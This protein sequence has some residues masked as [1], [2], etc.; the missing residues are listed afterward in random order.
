MKRPYLT[1]AAISLLILGSGLSGHSRTAA[2]DREN[3]L[4]CHKYPSLA[5]IDEEGR[6][7]NYN[8]NGSIFMNSL[9]GKV[10]CRDCHTYI[11][12]FPH[13]PVTEKVNC[14]NICHIVPPFA[15]AYFSH[16]KIIGV[17]DSS[18]H[19][20]K[21]DDSPL[22]K[23]SD[24]DC[25]Y[26]HL[27]P[28]YLRVDERTIAYGKTL[29]RCL[30]CHQRA[31]VSEAYRHIMHRLR[32]K[33]SRSSQ[34]IAS[35]CGGC[36]ADI[37]LM[38]ELGLT[39]RALDAVHT[40]EESIHGKMTT[41]GSQK[42]ADCIS[43]HASSQI[44]DIYKSDNPKSTINEKNLPAT[45]RNCHKKINKY[46]VQIAVHPSIEAPHNPVLFI[47][48]NMVLRLILYGTVFG[49]MGL[50]F[51]ETFRRKRDGAHIQL[52]SGTSWPKKKR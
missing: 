39:G 11:K 40:Y 21:P 30:N 1:L 52:K 37:S 13:A 36:H 12:K 34:K 46:F 5:R 42:A 41:L 32:H 45:C 50:L 23:A 44:H 49:L 24:P 27:N 51:M 35:L 48:N 33:T 19:A 15:E 10:G 4:M 31:G 20:V 7:K 43:C 3:C 26:C 29:D 47:I 18:I 16:K 14:A 25:K 2:A 9:H 8:V 28:V 38:K 22:M 17:F 6:V